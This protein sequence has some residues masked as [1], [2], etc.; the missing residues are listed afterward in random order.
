[1]WEARSIRKSLSMS[2]RVLLDFHGNSGCVLSIREF[3]R[4]F[5][6]FEKGARLGRD[7]H[8]VLPDEDGG[9]P[10]V[11]EENHVD[12]TYEDGDDVDSDQTEKRIEHHLLGRHVIALHAD[13]AQRHAGKNQEQNVA[14]EEHQTFSPNRQTRPLWLPKVCLHIQQVQQVQS[15][16]EEP[17]PHVLFPPKGTEVFHAVQSHQNQV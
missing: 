15:H 8:D 4:L 9:N 16:P 17:T 5:S 10:A 1:M 6:V 12:A 13:L 3:S 11:L 2:Q 14:V 7:G